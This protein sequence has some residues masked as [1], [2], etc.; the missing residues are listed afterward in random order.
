[1]LQNIDKV[2]KLIE[3]KLVQRKGSRDNKMKHKV[4]KTIQHQWGT[5]R[6]NQYK[7][8][9]IKMRS[10]HRWMSRMSR[11]ESLIRKNISKQLL[12]CNNNLEELREEEWW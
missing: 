11:K 12:R 3:E 8:L 9:Q 2:W 5:D 6:E 1:M 7:P 10:R 4:R